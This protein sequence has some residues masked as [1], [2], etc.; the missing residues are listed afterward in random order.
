[1]DKAVSDELPLVRPHRP[2]L[3]GPLLVH[4]TR[5]IRAEADGELEAF[6]LRARHVVA[7][8]LLRTLGEQ[9]QASLAETLRMNPVNVVGLLNE[10]EAAGLIQRRR[11]PQDRRRHTVA[12]STTGIRR[13]AEVEEALA[14]AE[15]RVLGALDADQLAS[16]QQLLQ[17][18]TATAA[19]DAGE[20]IAAAAARRPRN[21]AARRNR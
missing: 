2:G 20:P 14:G 3:V 12:I 5:R 21:R 13:L 18:A 19:P 11:F 4:L 9:S 10:L 6:D 16:F 17:I 7:L 1:M 8:T 15:A